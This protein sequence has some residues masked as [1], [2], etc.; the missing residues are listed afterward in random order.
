[1]LSTPTPSPLP[2]P[3]QSSSIFPVPSHLPLTDFVL[4][5]DYALVRQ[6][7]TRTATASHPVPDVTR[8]LTTL[9]S[10]TLSGEPAAMKE[11]TGPV[12]WKCTHQGCD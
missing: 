7:S 1:M 12:K 11:K 10:S 4:P 5:I 2:P 8:S 6:T 9:I 3:Q